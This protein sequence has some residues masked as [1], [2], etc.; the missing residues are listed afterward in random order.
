MQNAYQMVI[1]I[2]VRAPL[3]LIFAIVACF[4]SINRND[5]D[6]CLCDHLLAAVLSIIMKIVYPSSQVFEAYNLNNS[7]KKTSPIC[8]G[9]VLR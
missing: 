4:F 5:H 9:Q 8:G 1:R 7:I 2:C 3:N 6:L